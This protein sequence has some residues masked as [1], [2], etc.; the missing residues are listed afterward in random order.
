[1]I[2]SLQKFTTHLGNFFIKSQ[3]QHSGIN[4]N[5]WA[6]DREWWNKRQLLKDDQQLLYAYERPDLFLEM[7]SCYDGFTLYDILEMQPC[8]DG[9]TLYDVDYMFILWCWLH[10]Y[11]MIEFEHLVSFLSI[12]DVILMTAK[13]VL[14]TRWGK[15]IL[16]LSSSHTQ[17]VKG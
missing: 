1:M 5:R 11:I 15:T 7:Q 16:R 12:V 8:Y 10:V 9:F 6:S 3:F 13:I 4:L 2:M 17:K 14:C